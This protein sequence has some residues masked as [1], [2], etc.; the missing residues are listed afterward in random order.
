MRTSRMVRALLR[1]LVVV[2]VLAVPAFAADTV[3][4]AV[5]GGSFV[6]AGR[7]SESPP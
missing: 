7:A 1:A 3:V 2:A 6:T 5:T 4:N